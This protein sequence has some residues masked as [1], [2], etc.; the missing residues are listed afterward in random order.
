MGRNYTGPARRR[1][2]WAVQPD[3]RLTPLKRPDRLPE[4]GEVVF[5]R[6]GERALINSRSPKPLVW[7][8][9]HGA[10]GMGHG[11]WGMGHDRMIKRLGQ[12]ANCRGPAANPSEASGSFSGQG[13]QLGHNVFIGHFGF[14]AT[15]LSPDGRWLAAVDSARG[16]PV[17]VWDLSRADD[18]DP[19][20][21][22]RAVCNLE[23]SACITRLCAKITKAVGEPQ[24][25]ELVWSATTPSRNCAA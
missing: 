23:D 21:S 25:R 12:E 13:V 14:A 15:A 2:F 19:A 1:P 16:V 11:A 18:A 17:V 6:T 3:L 8:M 10:W 7:G 22:L 5:D 24:L 20:S 4:F 9:G